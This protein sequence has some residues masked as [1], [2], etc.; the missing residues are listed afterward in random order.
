MGR[1]LAHR[2]ARALPDELPSRSVGTPPS[3]YEHR[4]D[5]VSNFIVRRKSVTSRRYSP[6]RIF[7]LVIHFQRRSEAAHGEAEE[8]TQH[9][10]SARDEKPDTDANRRD[11]A[12]ETEI[13]R[14]TQTC[15]ADLKASVILQEI[16]HS[17]C[18]SWRIIANTAAIMN[19]LETTR[20]TKGG[21]TIEDSVIH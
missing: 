11:A 12:T 9:A 21:H 14:Q 20:R 16:K 1:F 2:I 3:Y 13:R 4:S 6:L 8:G 5:G 7:H 17:R 19:V 15:R 18:Y 10:H